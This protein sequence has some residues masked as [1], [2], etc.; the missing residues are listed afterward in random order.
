LNE[1]GQFGPVGWSETEDAGS[2]HCKV[3]GC[4]YPSPNPGAWQ[5]ALVTS[6]SRP[7]PQRVAGGTAFFFLFHAFTVYRLKSLRY[8]TL[9]EHF[10]VLLQIW[11]AKVEVKF[12]RNCVD[13]NAP[14]E[15]LDADAQAE[16]DGGDDEAP[17]DVES[18]NGSFAGSSP[19]GSS[20]HSPQASPGA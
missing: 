9:V 20:P 12:L 5:A 14:K 15:P 6:A 19:G 3:N 11:R 18:D 2:G 1:G 13:P 16:A 4:D 7:P 10:S 17:Q 8:R